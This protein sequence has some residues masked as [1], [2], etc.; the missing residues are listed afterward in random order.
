MFYAQVIQPCPFVS[1]ALLNPDTPYPRVL[2]SAVLLSY[3][4]FIWRAKVNPFAAR[5]G[6]V[7]I[8]DPQMET[9]ELVRALLV[10][11]RP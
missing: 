5:P 7:A 11:Q 2:R 4:L 9:A 3:I 1:F 6:G 8:F 10:S